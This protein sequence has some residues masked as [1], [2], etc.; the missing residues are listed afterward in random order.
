[1][2]RTMRRGSLGLTRVG[3]QEQ[4]KP[5]DLPSRRKQKFPRSKQ[6]HRSKKKQREMLFKAQA[7]ADRKTKEATV[8]GG[9]QSASALSKG[10]DAGASAVGEQRIMID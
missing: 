9:S 8:D 2:K 3:D 6:P 4:K 10:F 5:R 1:M 7:E